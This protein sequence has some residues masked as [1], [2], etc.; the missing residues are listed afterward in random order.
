MTI[1][2]NN[3]TFELYDSKERLL[4]PEQFYKAKFFALYRENDIEGSVLMGIHEFPKKLGAFDK[5]LVIVKVRE[6]TRKKEARLKLKE[7]QDELVKL[8]EEDFKKYT[9]EVEAEIKEEEEEESKTITYRDIFEKDDEVFRGNFNSPKL[10]SNAQ[11]MT[12]R[13]TYRE[14]INLKEQILNISNEIIK[15]F[16]Q[17]EKIYLKSYNDKTIN[18]ILYL[19]FFVPPLEGGSM[20]S[21]VVSTGYSLFKKKE[22][23]GLEGYNVLQKLIKNASKERYLKTYGEDNIG[24]KGFEIEVIWTV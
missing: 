7:R 21:S 2:R 10:E 5:K 8:L 17:L 22:D 9:D 11:S 16:N 24:L 20:Y 12:I 19:K 3:W 18:N 15:S 4:S 13:T 1:T 23:I 14:T 6:Y